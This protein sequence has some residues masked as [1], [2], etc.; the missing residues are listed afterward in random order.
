MVKTGVVDPETTKAKMSPIID[1]IFLFFK[2]CIVS[3]EAPSGARNPIRRY[4]KDHKSIF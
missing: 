2:R 4:K 3:L 1:E